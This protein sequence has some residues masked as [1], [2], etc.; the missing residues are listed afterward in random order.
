[1]EKTYLADF[2]ANAHVA[3]A[4]ASRALREPGSSPSAVM[5]RKCQ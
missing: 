2:W 1:M 3:A 4:T 5:R